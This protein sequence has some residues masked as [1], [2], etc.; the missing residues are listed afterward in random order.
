MRRW[1][2]GTDWMRFCETICSLGRWSGGTRGRKQSDLMTQ[3]HLD[4]GF[5]LSFKEWQCEA[6][7]ALKHP[8]PHLL[9]NN[10]P[11]PLRSS[12]TLISNTYVEGCAFIWPFVDERRISSVHRDALKGGRSCHERGRCVLQTSHVW[13]WQYRGLNPGC[14]VHCFYVADLKWSAAHD[15]WGFEYDAQ[16]VIRIQ[17]WL[18]LQVLVE[19][20]EANMVVAGGRPQPDRVWRIMWYGKS[21]LREQGEIYTMLHI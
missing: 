2:L 4:R 20:L 15:G 8:T 6:D 14:Q 18:L 12:L 21:G 19:R 7:K 17:M 3:H 5:F 9:E 1:P 10:S 13:I 11:L 16:V